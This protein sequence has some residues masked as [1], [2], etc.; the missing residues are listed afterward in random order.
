[1]G[2]GSGNYTLWTFQATFINTKFT[3]LSNNYDYTAIRQA[4][5]GAKVALVLVMANSRED[6]IIVDRNEGDRNNLIFWQNGDALIAEV[7]SVNP[8]T[9]IVINPAGLPGQEP[10]NAITDML[11]GKIN[12]S[13]KSVFTWRKNR[14]DWGVDVFFGLSYMTFEYSNLKIEKKDVGPY[15]PTM[16]K[17]LSAL[18]LSSENY[19]AEDLSFLADFTVLPGYIYPWENAYTV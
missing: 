2:W 4:A 8:N 18:T 16:G 14:T 6:Y 12:P 1:M 17:T 11:Y 9:I 7:A 15:T 5:S 19:T 13:G 3:N 10:G